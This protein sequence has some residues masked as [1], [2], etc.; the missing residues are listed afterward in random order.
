V[1]HVHGELDAQM[2]PEGQ[3]NGY[4]PG[5]GIQTSPLAEHMLLIADRN[6]SRDQ[7]F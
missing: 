3:S 6:G 5:S 7:K 4:Y 1:L 2:N